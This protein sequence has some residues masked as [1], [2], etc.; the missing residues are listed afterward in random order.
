MAENDT[1][2]ITI[3]QYN[4]GYDIPF[5]CLD[6]DGTAYDLS[7]LT[8]LKL[9]VWKYRDVADTFLT[10]TMTVDDATLGTCHYTVVEHDFDVATTYQCVV[11]GTDGGSTRLTWGPATLTVRAV[12]RSV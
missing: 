10:G 3:A 2:V 6:A 8:D 7:A 1:L 5:V 12:P 11:E 9:L 4:F